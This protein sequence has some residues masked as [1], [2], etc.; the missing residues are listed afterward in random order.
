MISGGGDYGGW[1]FDFEG[2]AGF[3]CG[4]ALGAVRGEG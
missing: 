1:V 4:G 2:A 3:G